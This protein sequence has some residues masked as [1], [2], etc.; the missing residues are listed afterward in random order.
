MSTPERY[1][2]PAADRPLLFGDVFSAD[3]LHD[4]MINQEAVALAAFNARGGGTAY[5][6][7]SPG[8]KRRTGLVLARGG[9]C[10]AVLLSDDCEI[11]TWLGRKGGGGR[12]LFAALEEWPADVDERERIASSTSFRRHPLLPADGFEGGVVEFFRLFAVSGKSLVDSHGRLLSLTDPARA[13]LEQRWAAYATRRG[14]MAAERNGSKLAYVLEAGD[15]AAKWEQLMK[16]SATPAAP[17][18]DAGARL[19]TAL[20][21]AWRVEGEIAGKFA[22]AYEE[23]RN[24]DDAVPL[25]QEELRSLSRLATEAADALDL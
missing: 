18:V 3:W 23:K 15:D 25:L 21:Q 1:I 4:A 8:T 16:G 24:G 5:T 10:R 7:L 9:P 13:E 11:E 22:D 20:A 12:L 6:P 19:A 17:H 2:T 14:P